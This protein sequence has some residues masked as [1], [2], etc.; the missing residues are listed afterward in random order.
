MFKKSIVILAIAVLV[1]TIPVMAEE[2]AANTDSKSSEPKVAAVVNGEKITVNEVDQFANT[3]K[4]VMTLYQNNQQFAQLLLQTESGQNLLNEFR[5]TKLDS[6]VTME[7]LKMKAEDKNINLSQQEKNSMFQQQV[8]SIKQSN[9]FNDEQLMSALSKQGISSLDQYKKM[10]LENNKSNLLINK[11]MQEVTGDISVSD[12]A[13]R[14]YYN[15]NKNQFKNKEQINASHILVKDKEKADEVM[16]KLN[17]GT[18][19]SKLAEE[20]SQGPTAKKGGDLGY[21]SKG[22]MVP[23][24]EKA[25]FAMKPGEISKEPVKTD[26][27]YHIIKVKG[28]KES[29]ISTFEEVKNNI[30][31]KLLNQK[32]QNKWTDYVSNLR[33]EATIEKKL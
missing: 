21:F 20:Y 27:G 8:N 28:K 9:K 6:L 16:K 13:A 17:N 14:E 7:L 10:F 30:K 12:E 25:A 4:L 22:Q 2:G 26:Y 32:R 15:N 11:L 19:F 1:F 18:D 24:F 23:A 3:Q 33:K 31:Q 5:K 29:D